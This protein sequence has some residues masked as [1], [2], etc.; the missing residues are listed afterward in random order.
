MII[1]IIVII[2]LFIGVIYFLR[3]MNTKECMAPL[4]VYGTEYIYDYLRN[5]PIFVI[6]LKDRPNRRIEAISELHRNGLQATFV[7]A[8][9]GRTLD[10]NYLRNKK[11]I[12]DHRKY[13]KLRRGEI[14]CYLSHLKCWQSILES[15]QPYGMVLEDDFVFVD[16]FKNKFNGIFEH[17]KDKEWDIINLGRRCRL[18]LADKNCDI[19]TVVYKD[20]FHPKIVGYGAYAYIIK[21]S[22]I[23]KLTKIIYPI[24]KPIDVAIPD[25]HDKGNIKVLVFSKD[26]AD[27]RSIKNSDT[28]NI[29]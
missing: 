18:V 26:L 28:T 1:I 12:I 29:I 2:I 27:V 23:N 8:V 21:A 6:N 5:M 7:D 17:I 25:E 20:A 11:I 24:Y 16:G 9:D 14:G 22:T 15:K 19:G 13:R 10:V 3:N 4:D